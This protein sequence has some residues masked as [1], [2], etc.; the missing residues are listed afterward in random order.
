MAHEDRIKW[1]A[2]YREKTIHTDPSGILTRYWHLASSGKALDIACGGGRNSL[3]LAQNGFDVDAVDIST[4]ATDH[5]AGR[6]PHI[7]VICQD[8]DTWKIPINRYDL[9]VNIRFLDRHL[10][11][12]IQKGLKIGGLLVFESFLNG[13][14]DKYCLKTNELLHVFDDFRIIYY[15]EKKTDHSEKY[16]QVASLVAMKYEKFKLDRGDGARLP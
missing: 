1:D 13:E 7:R 6:H 4:V 16:D 12:Q 2:K 3:F 10:F 8:L 15:E 9:I 11:P 14:I 5:L